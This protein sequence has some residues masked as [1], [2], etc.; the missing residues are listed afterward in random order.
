MTKDKSIF[1]DIDKFVNVKVQL[2]NNT[3]VKSQG[4]RT[5]MV[6]TKKGTQFIKDVLLV[7]NLKENLLS[8]GQMMENEY[9]FHFEK[10]T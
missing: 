1:K 3:T 2:G 9:F 6:E 4:K 5:I 10:D 7:P 8:I